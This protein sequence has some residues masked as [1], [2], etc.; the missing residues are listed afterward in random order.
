MN[1]KFFESELKR[2]Q[3]RFNQT[4]G[5]TEFCNLKARQMV[6]LTICSMHT[7]LTKINNRLPDQPAWK[8]ITKF[9]RARNVLESIYDQFEHE[10]KQR[11]N[12]NQNSRQEKR[13][14]VTA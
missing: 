9:M 12:L 1:T 8:L 2:M 5:A 4:F 7:T 14:T 11:A 6:I 13:H 10:A 3:N